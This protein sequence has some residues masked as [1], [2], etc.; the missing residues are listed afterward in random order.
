MELDARNFSDVKP[1]LLD[2]IKSLSP[3]LTCTV[4]SVSVQLSDSVVTSTDADRKFS[5]V[6]GLPSTN[7][8]Y[9]DETNNQGTLV[10]SQEPSIICG[11]D[12]SS[13]SEDLPGYP[14][15][16]VSFE[17]IGLGGID[18]FHYNDAMILSGL[19]SNWYDDQ[20]QYASE[21]LDYPLMDGCLFA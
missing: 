12:F 9:F 16:G 3:S 11:A 6:E 5:S 7:D 10:R 17:N 1:G 19:Q 21:T 4:D 13:L 14:L 15:Q 20:D 18:L 8:C 2:C